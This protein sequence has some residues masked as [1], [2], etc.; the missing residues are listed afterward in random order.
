MHLSLL[1]ITPSPKIEV[2]TNNELREVLERHD[3]EVL[4]GVNE[5]LEYYDSSHSKPL[6]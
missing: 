4:A 2:P 6:G 1:G 5:I 3:L